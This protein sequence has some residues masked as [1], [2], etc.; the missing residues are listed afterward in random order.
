MSE[1]NSELTE[2]AA[3]AAPATETVEEEP[4]V[5]AHSAD[6]EDPGVCVGVYVYN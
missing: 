6:D 5:V 4:E 3:E 1:E 2:A